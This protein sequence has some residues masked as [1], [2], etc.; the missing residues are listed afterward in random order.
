MEN[1]CKRVQVSRSTRGLSSPPYEVLAHIATKLSSYCH[2]EVGQDRQNNIDEFLQY[3][4]HVRNSNA[5][6]RCRERLDYELEWF[7]DSLSIWE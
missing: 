1:K 7:Y 6:L 3:F 4:H 5:I 2:E